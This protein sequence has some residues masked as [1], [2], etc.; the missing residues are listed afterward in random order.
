MYQLQ[1]YGN[2]WMK[3]LVSNFFLQMQTIK[4]EMFFKITIFLRKFA[5]LQNLYLL[6]YPISFIKFVS[7]TYRLTKESTFMYQ[8][9]TYILT[10]LTTEDMALTH[11]IM[12]HMSAK[13]RLM[14][15]NTSWRHR[16]S[17][18]PSIRK[19]TTGTMESKLLDKYIT[20]MKINMISSKYW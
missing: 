5:Q 8:T 1:L 4:H 20:T 10:I 16:L 17:W 12:N 19:V 11:T 6:H 7:D 3:I 13:R 9:L 2:D 15:I 18:T 14:S